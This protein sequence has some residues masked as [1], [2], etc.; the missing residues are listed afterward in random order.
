MSLIEVNTTIPSLLARRLSDGQAL[1]DALDA[2]LADW[3]DVHPR[4]LEWRGKW[5]LGWLDLPQGGADYARS[6]ELGS[7]FS[8]EYETLIVCG[9]GGSALGTQAVYSALDNPGEP[10]RN[11]YVLDNVD[12]LQIAAVAARVDW[13]TTAVNVISKSG[14]TLETM[15]GFL[16]LLHL[17]AQSG[18]DADALNTRVIATTD[19]ARGLLRELATA[20]GWETLPV[21]SD[22]GGRFSVLSAVGILPLAFAGVNTDGLIGGARAFQ[23]A[24]LSRNARDN[25]ALRLALLHYLL[26]TR[27]NLNIC[28]QY[29]YG[30]PLVL[31]GDWFRQLWA[32]S[33]AKDKQIGGARGL[34]CMTPVTA[35]GTT[36][37]HSQ[38]QLYME[39]PDDKLYGV[40]SAGEWAVDPVL[41]MRADDLPPALAYMGGQSFGS[42]LE[43]CRSGTRDALVEAGRPVYEINFP[44]VTAYQVGAYLQLW[45]LAT[46]YAGL[47]YEVNPFDQPGVERGKIIT[48][49]LMAG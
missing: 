12:P 18:L 16:Y 33:L 47:I 23:E 35:R 5:P 27:G 37:Q 26:H 42:I 24:L 11:V 30:D 41:D 10:L 25:E 39:G 19:P 17:M 45:M 32:E 49:A 15:S 38:N 21:P 13:E 8:E 36:D 3:R 4:L 6:V 7:R 40:I 28:V 22:V 14:E 1:G 29:T 34:G 2:A 9:I 20:R 43:A 48:R 46:A 44:R 31:L